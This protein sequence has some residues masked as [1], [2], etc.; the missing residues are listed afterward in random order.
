LKKFGALSSRTGHWK[1]TAIE[2]PNNRNP[3]QENVIMWFTPHLRDRHASAREHARRSPVKPR[4]LRPRL[5]ALE[6][7]ML[8][9]PYPVTS[10]LDSGPG[11]LR[12]AIT[13]LDANGGSDNTIDF[14]INTGNLTIE[15]ASPLPTITAP[16]DIDGDSQ[17]GVEIV[18]GP[19]FNSGLKL[20]AGSDGSIVQGLSIV[21]LEGGA[22]IDID[23][24]RDQVTGNTIG[25]V[26]DANFAGDEFG[27]HVG[28]GGIDCTIGGTV[29]GDANIISGNT[30]YGID[31]QGPSCTVVGNLIGTDA[32]GSKSVPNGSGIFI[33][34]GNETTI[35]G[36]A[37]YDANII[38]GNTSYGI[39]VD[40]DAPCT[41]EGNLIGTDKSGTLP[42]PNGVSGVFF[43]ADSNSA[44]TLGV[45][46]SPNIIAFNS[47]PGVATAPGATGRTVR[48]NSIFR[49]A[50]PG[51][52]LGND[53]VTPNTL[54]G[55]NNTPVMS[56][57]E[58]GIVSGY[59]NA[60]PDSIYVI[61]FYGNPSDDASSARPQGRTF[62]GSTDISTNGGGNG[63]FQ[64]SYTPDGSQPFITATATDASG[65]TSEFSA[66]VVP[67]T[68]TGLTI[69]ATAG[70]PSTVQAAVFT[71]MDQSAVSADFTAAID[72][73]DG[74]QTTGTVVASPGG[75]VV[76]G[77]HTFTAANP[78]E[79]VSVTVTDTH[80]AISS[81]VHS[82]AVVAGPSDVVTAY[83][84]NT[85][86]VA[87][88][89]FTAVVASFTDTNVRAIAGQF[90]ATINWE[91]GTTSTGT[92]SIDGAGFDVT[93][94]HTYNVAGSDTFAVTITD[95]PTGA[96]V[97]T[98]PTANVLPVPITIQAKNFDVTGGKRF[99]GTVAT[100]VDGDPRTDPTFYTA[101]INWGDNTP[102]TTGAITGTNPFTV[103]AWHM[104]ASFSG[105]DLVMITIVDKNGRT[106]MAFD[107]VVDPPAVLVIETGEIT[108]PK[109][110]VF[111]GIV[112]TFTDAGPAEPAG[113][114]KATFDWGKGRKTAGMIAGSNGR[115]VVSARHTFSRFTGTRSVI[116]T[117]A[118]PGGQSVSVV[119]SAAEIV[120]HPG[121]IVATHRGRGTAKRR[122]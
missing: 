86:F 104:F 105:T 59:L 118:G 21:G 29:S 103:M 111:S 47:G 119:E 25:S 3:E 24:A 116:V 87:G 120:H 74:V 17:P 110:G 38:S 101:T 8:L 48:F 79:P 40:I 43:L 50:G 67:L 31:I 20:G 42:V 68:A 60:S 4:A 18:G 81:T 39:V 106:A 32:S 76:V 84:R 6:G 57:A 108:V 115:F 2:T 98:Y 97:T 34:G 78:A 89:P 30:S 64:F 14:A 77:S 65:I 99:S 121:A 92:V 5:E 109:S 107:R 70:V 102:T 33:F 80:T 112:A 61:D 23:S 88:A 1:Q 93:G 27:I 75:F 83:G 13:T 9:T 69:A 85:S 44:A 113:A 22:G 12:Q 52:D 82:L 117:V 45:P 36:T 62:L 53:D 37:S 56:S 28:H 96:A 54:G 66:P 90:A 15:L 100:F 35:G 26:A 73:G 46:G 10:N 41:V 16:V 11:T 72:W 63:F 71:S 95:L 58:D 91:D 94:A 49:N 7:R 55:A 122:S 114:Y 51:I 19:F